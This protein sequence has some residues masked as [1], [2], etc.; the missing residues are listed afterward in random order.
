MN[1]NISTRDDAEDSHLTFTETTVCEPSLSSPSSSR[2]LPDLL[3]ALIG[4]RGGGHASPSAGMMQEVEDVSSTSFTST[5]PAA[6][7]LMTLCFDLHEFVDV[8]M[9]SPPSWEG[10]SI[11]DAQ[12]INFE[13]PAASSSSLGVTQDTN[14]QLTHASPPSLSPSSASSCV[15]PTSFEFHP[16]E[17]VQHKCQEG[18]SLETLHRDL[19]TLCSTLEKAI[20]IEV[21][22]SLPPSAVQDII[23]KSRSFRQEIET[24]IPVE[25]GEIS[26]LLEGACDAVDTTLVEVKQKLDAAA[27]GSAQQ[28]FD[29]SFLRVMLL[30]DS[31][32]LLGLPFASSI[33]DEDDEVE[34]DGG[35]CSSTE[36]GRG[37][38]SQEE[39]RAAETRRSELT[40]Y[41]Q[42]KGMEGASW[43][44]EDF[45][46]L[47]FPL[48]FP[49]SVSSFSTSPSNTGWKS[50]A[51]A[52]STHDH[53]HSSVN[54]LS[55]RREQAHHWSEVLMY[56]GPRGRTRRGYQPHYYPPGNPNHSEISPSTS[57]SAVAGTVQD[58]NA[59]R[60]MITPLLFSRIRTLQQ[61]VGILCAL[62]E[63]GG[64]DWSLFKKARKGTEQKGKHLQKEYSEETDN[65]MGE[66]GMLSSSLNVKSGKEEE[67]GRTP[68]DPL[69]AMLE[70]DSSRAQEAERALGWCEAAE[71]AILKE[72]ESVMAEVGR[73]YFY[74]SQKDARDERDITDHYERQRLDTKHLY[75]IK[76]G[77]AVQNGPS[78]DVEEGNDQASSSSSKVSDPSPFV[79]ESLS[80]MKEVVLLYATLGA[81]DEFIDV[82]QKTVVIPFL[83]RV[84]SW[85]TATQTLHHVE[86]TLSLLYR[87]G[88][89][90]Q[91]HISPLLA[92]W[93]S[94]FSP[95]GV[96]GPGG[97]HVSSNCYQQQNVGHSRDNRGGG[98]EDVQ[99]NKTEGMGTE[100]CDTVLFSSTRIS[101]GG[102]GRT[103]STNVASGRPI[104]PQTAMASRGKD[105]SPPL[106]SQP[107]SFSSSSSTCLFPVADIIWPAVCA[108]LQEKISRSLFDVNILENFRR[109][110]IAASVLEQKIFDLCTFP[111]H[112][113]PPFTSWKSER[114]SGGSKKKIMVPPGHA[115]VV[116]GAEE[117]ERIRHAAVTLEWH[118]QWRVDVYAAQCVMNIAKQINKDVEQ[119]E[120]IMQKTLTESQ[121]YVS[122]MQEQH[123]RFPPNL[124][125][126]FTPPGS[127]HQAHSSTSVLG[128]ESAVG[129]GEDLHD[130]LQS[131]NSSSVPSSASCGARKSPGLG[132]KQTS[133]AV[134]TTPGAVPFFAALES[135]ARPFADTSIHGGETP[136][137]SAWCAASSAL[138][139]LWATL[140]FSFEQL[141][142][143]QFLPAATPIFLHQCISSCKAVTTFLHHDIAEKMLITALHSPS[144]SS[145][146]WG[147]TRPRSYS[148]SQQT[149][150]GTS[151]SGTSLLLSM[152]SSTSVS[153]SSASPRHHHN[154]DN[155]DGRDASAGGSPNFHPFVKDSGSRNVQDDNFLT[156]FADHPNHHDARSVF[157][158]E[159]YDDVILHSLFLLI[160]VFHGMRSLSF[161]LSASG[162]A[163]KI[164][165]A[166]VSPGDTAGNTEPMR[167][168]SSSSCSSSLTSPL[169][170][171]PLTTTTE[172]Q[173]GTIETTTPV[174]STKITITVESKKSSQDGSSIGHRCMAVCTWCSENILQQHYYP[175]LH[176]FTDS[177]IIPA[178]V[179]PLQHIKS[180]RAV[181]VHT[182]KDPPSKPS[183]YVPSVL[184]PLKV[185]CRA[186]EAHQEL[187][188]TT[189]FP[190]FCKGGRNNENS[191]TFASSCVPSSLSSSPSTARKMGMTAFQWDMMSVLYQIR[192]AVVERFFELTK[193]TLEAARKADEG[194]EKLRRKREAATAAAQAAA[195]SPTTTICTSRAG[196]DGG[197][198]KSEGT[199]NCTGTAENSI[200]S[201]ISS[202]VDGTP[203]ST[204]PSHSFAM[205]SDRDKIMIQL[206]L[207][208]K[209]ITQTI[210]LLIHSFPSSPS[211]SSE[212]EK[213][214]SDRCFMLEKR[215][216]EKEEE[217]LHMLHNGQS[218]F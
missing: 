73:L 130:G 167:S 63:I 153:F 173:K 67:E 98:E 59:S 217:L 8:S 24:N 62:Y 66:K 120:G 154:M 54:A 197:G 126:N 105:E 47:P 164:V 46:D 83:Q 100:E 112:C 186:W 18:A 10:R 137:L 201:F 149:M 102:S 40:S 157:L 12:K 170:S 175:L 44:E 190:L 144:F 215:G 132:S 39:K 43:K 166:A 58:A 26:R 205:F 184:Q 182:Q 216:R 49:S 158:P 139:S 146:T 27:I 37:G 91:H 96:V 60:Y 71:R 206:Y 68:K 32:T 133:A 42:K 34:A 82:C 183:W 23:A 142:I 29:D 107:L 36:S 41:T 163:G 177:I 147:H 129:A 85:T 70:M 1:T 15:P 88:E 151:S 168:A 160:S 86:S 141:F 134:A 152:A 111:Q 110:Y 204:S 14:S 194:W 103:S 79:S 78:A 172:V 117:R 162:E 125:K 17:F 200:T 159:E 87:L 4:A 84:V 187:H 119:C 75:S 202:S 38:G 155:G 77:Q 203:G 106:R 57:S 65:L 136:L 53:S 207:D 21:E 169:T 94:V 145:L 104:L 140:R 218:V 99:M 115:E 209:E 50:N 174:A 199:N 128:G 210:A 55:Y 212:E 131:M 2:G 188:L 7:P 45:G 13:C 196:G 109:K 198:G 76:G 143:H 3:L 33:D 179:H 208:A 156:P 123:P 72:M 69:C 122:A 150:L 118:R 92:L 176:H 97:V 95:L 31:L 191:T 19:T 161:F 165:R 11:G 80:M 124:N 101:R 211:S 93:R 51:V 192:L 121:N 64:K 181:F 74:H 193:E 16:F 22:H 28:F 5:A 189:T 113:T 195:A 214:A 9:A 35:N 61:A 89:V 114:G 20:Q 180:V 25:L 90:I 185:F 52:T 148:F 116:E 178:C 171:Y 127:I 81:V 135:T 56:G 138:G 48:V 6:L 108:V 30:Y 213:G